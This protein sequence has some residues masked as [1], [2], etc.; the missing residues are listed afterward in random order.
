MAVSHGNTLPVRSGR[1][2][3]EGS[4]G[5]RISP[6]PF[7]AV[8]I[9]FSSRAWGR[10]TG[11]PQHQ[12]P[13]RA[14]GLPEAVSRSLSTGAQFTPVLV[15]NAGRPALTGR[16]MTSIPSYWNKRLDRATG[17]G[18]PFV[19][20]P[21]STPSSFIGHLQQLELRLKGL[22]AQ[23]LV[24]LLP[25]HDH[26]AHQALGRN[27]LSPEV[28]RAGLVALSRHQIFRSS[29][30]RFPAGIPRCCAGLPVPGCRG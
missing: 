14:M 4:S 22:I 11:S 27:M 12:V 16:F 10:G 30:P 19:I 9:C 25:P 7:P 5:G 18:R 26:D 21:A 3:I 28:V 23:T 2:G 6:N 17:N 24:Q 15:P 8:L 29:R 1:K 20:T 13:G